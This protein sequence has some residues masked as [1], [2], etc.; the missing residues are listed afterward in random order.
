MP[1]S[2]TGGSPP[3]IYIRIHIRQS[4]IAILRLRRRNGTAGGGSQV[5]VC[6]D[7]LLDMLTRRGDGI[8]MA[9]ITGAALSR[10][11]IRHRSDA[12]MRLRRRPGFANRHAVAGAE[13]MDSELAFAPA[14][15][16]RRM[17]AGGEVSSV[18]LTEL[19]YRR[20]EALNPQLN[21]YLVLCPR[22]GAGGGASRR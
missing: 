22:P 1:Q 14:T 21:A 18:E 12:L 9:A 7:G 4:G 3:F 10:P 16:L 17:I 20:I 6:A 19:F 11:V 8:I 13:P 15:E 2:A 5:R